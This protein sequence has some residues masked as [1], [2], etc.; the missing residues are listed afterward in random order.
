MNAPVTPGGTVQMPQHNVGGVA[1]QVAAERAASG[2]TMTAAEQREI[3]ASQALLDARAMPS[4][5]LEGEMGTGKTHSLQTLLAPG[6]GIEKVIMMTNEAGFEDVVGHIPA[7]KLDWIYVPVAE[8]S[9]DG[10]IQ[11]AKIIN[12]QKPDA[13]QAMGGINRHMY[14][15]FDQILGYCNNFVGQRT[16]QNYGPVFKFPNNWCL[17]YESI[18]A[19]TE[20]AKNCAIGDKPFMEMRDYQM[21]QT[22]IKKFLNHLVFSTKCLFVATAHLERETN[23]T[24]GM[25]ELMVSTVGRKLAPMIPRFFSD[26]IITDRIDPLG[27]QGTVRPDFTWAT[28]KSGVRSKTRNLPWSTKLQPD[29]G[30][31]LDNFRKRQAQAKAGQAPVQP[32]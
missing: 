8:G 3:M 26:V 23:E 31:L 30:P 24:T 9:F 32:Q 13:I 18:S 22:M 15:Q 7:S 4:I 20:I 6:T 29:F 21:V 1:E 10:L 27:Q 2:G 11:M 19:L 12:T 17:W 28:V 14:P 16:G 25:S 5:I